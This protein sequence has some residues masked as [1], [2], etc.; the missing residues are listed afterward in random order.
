MQQ[1]IKWVGFFSV[2]SNSEIAILEKFRQVFL[3]SLTESA[4]VALPSTFGVYRDLLIKS[5]ETSG[6]H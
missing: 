2:E 3:P 6:E 5:R 4:N 1:Y